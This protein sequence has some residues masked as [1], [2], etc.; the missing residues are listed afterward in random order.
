MTRCHANTFRYV[1]SLI[2]ILL[3][4]HLFVFSASAIN[5]KIYAIDDQTAIKVIDDKIEVI[6]EGEHLELNI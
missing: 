1:M 3:L 4:W 2:M 5:G 6:S